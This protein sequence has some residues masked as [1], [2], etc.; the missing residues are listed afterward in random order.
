M[1]LEIS[2]ADLRLRSKVE[3]QLKQKLAKV[4]KLLKGFSFPEDLVFCRVKIDLN[5]TNQYQ[6]VLTLV[7]PYQTLQ[8]KARSHRINNAINEIGEILIR[9]VEKY[10][11]KI[12]KKSTFQKVA[13]QKRLG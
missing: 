7:L 2:S 12:T 8:A 3:T 4:Q 6:V 10:K 9:K 13:Q 5:P 11:A 1:R